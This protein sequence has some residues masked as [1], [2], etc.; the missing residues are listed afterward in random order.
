MNQPNQENKD[1]ITFD[2][3]LN[4]GSVPV[5]VVAKVY[6][7]DAQWIRTGIISGYLPIGFATRKGK[8]IKSLEEWQSEKGRVNYYISPRLLFEQTGY[9]YKGE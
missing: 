5:A 8:V 6:G 2:Q 7:K 4:I 1:Q 3:V 9:Q